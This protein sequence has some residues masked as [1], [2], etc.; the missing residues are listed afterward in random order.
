MFF[1][2]LHSKSEVEGHHFCP[3]A[4]HLSE[5]ITDQRMHAIYEVG[6]AEFEVYLPIRGV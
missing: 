1:V 3:R 4:V 5:S 2:L 6:Q